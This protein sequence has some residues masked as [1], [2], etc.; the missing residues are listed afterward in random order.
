MSQKV[1]TRKEEKNAKEK[2]EKK[3]KQSDDEYLRQKDLWDEHYKEIIN[4]K[5]EEFTPKQMSMIMRGAGIEDERE[6]FDIL[7]DE[8]NDPTPEQLAKLS[9][10]IAKSHKIVNEKKKVKTK[11]YYNNK[12]GGYGCGR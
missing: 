2:L 5:I 12:S 4:K 8:Y 6:L 3:R 9:E 10:Y 1:R 11:T 7:M